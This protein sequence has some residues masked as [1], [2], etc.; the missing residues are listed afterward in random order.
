MKVTL[1]FICLL[2]FG[3]YENRKSYDFSP[4]NAIWVESYYFRGFNSNYE[5]LNESKVRAFANR[6]KKHNIKYIYVFAGPFD[7]TGNLPEYSSSPLARKSIE[8]MLEEYPNL[9]ILPWIGGVQYKTVFLED[10][11]WFENAV[12]STKDLIKELNVPGVHLDFELI[13]KNAD[14]FETSLRNYSNN[15]FNIYPENLIRFHKFVRESMPE[16]YISTVV[17][18]SIPQSLT[19]KNKL[20]IKEIKELMRYVNEISYLFYDT[21]IKTEIKFQE[22][23]DSLIYS[24]IKLDNLFPHVK[25]LVSVGTFINY[26]ELRK[27]RDQNIESIENTF[28]SL[29][30]S[31]RFYDNNP[32]SGIS[33]YCNWQSAEVE[34]SEINSLSANLR[35]H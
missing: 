17:P 13:L 28:A 1:V 20:D 31:I 19:W 2:L 21:S 7:K 8:I 11:H 34:L 32:I 24:M 9:I 12:E 25:Q 15:D 30:R 16:I 3:C 4:G 33:I 14:F 29:D 18:A 27:Y 23:S 22:A 10:E 6:M 35:K 5:I 26:E